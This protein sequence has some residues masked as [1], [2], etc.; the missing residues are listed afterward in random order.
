LTP[1]RAARLARAVRRY[2]RRGGGSGGRAWRLLLA[3]AKRGDAAAA[4]V[5]AGLVE[6]AEPAA[7]ATLW[8]VTRAAGEPWWRGPLGEALATDPERI[9]PSI[10]D[11]FWSGWLST[12]NDE[13]LTRLRRWQRLPSAEP[14]AGLGRV[15]LGLPAPAAD[16]LAAARRDGHPIA[17]IARVRILSAAAH[18]SG[19][20]GSAGQ[21]DP[22][23]Q[24][25]PGGQAGSGSQPNLA[26]RELVEL[27]CAVAVGE[28]EGTIAVFC[29][30]NG[31]V[32]A[33]PVSRAVYLLGMGQI[34]QYCAADP[35]GSLLVAGYP[36]ANPAV[37]RRLREAVVTVGDLDLLA[38]VVRDRGRPAVWLEPAQL[39]RAGRRLAAA[40]AWDRLWRLARDV[41]LRQAIELTRLFDP[42]W[43]PPDEAGRRLFEQLAAAPP[44]LLAHAGKGAT[45]RFHSGQFRRMARLADPATPV[46]VAFAPDGSQLAILGWS[47]S[48]SPDQSAHSPPGATP[49]QVVGYDLPSGEP[50]W[51]HEVVPDLGFQVGQR[52]GALNLAH[53]GD[54]VVVACRRLVRVPARPGGQ[55]SDVGVF[56]GSLTPLPAGAVA[57]ALL[58]TGAGY[59][60][61]VYHP[62]GD[63]RRGGDVELCFGAAGLPP[64]TVRVDGL[65]TAWHL[66]SNVDSGRLSVWNWDWLPSG[67]HSLVDLDETGA[68]RRRAGGTHMG[69][70][71]PPVL[72]AD[73]LLIGVD[74][75]GRLARWRRTGDRLDIDAAAELDWKVDELCLLPGLVGVRHADDWGWF[76]T[77][78]L[79][80]TAA[81]YEPDA[82]WHGPLWTSSDG[83]WAAVVASS[84]GLDLYQMVGV[85]ALLGRPLAALRPAD[86]TVLATSPA[87]S[88][89]ADRM[90]LA[91]LRACADYRYGTEIEVTS[92]GRL[93]LADHD[94]T[95]ADHD[96]TLGEID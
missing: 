25:R 30:E 67:T 2:R 61:Q 5:L 80:D 94:I 17:E 92:A 85:A 38:R 48:A 74:R 7:V 11:T 16:V 81:P 3:R 63:P 91:L 58:P 49:V 33:D 65:R 68:V 41:R 71:P 14:D 82:A 52:Y 27:V 21:A 62:V 90:V 72:A 8:D 26:D 75:A 36:G 28:P 20:P 9:P 69:A 39:D 87:P 88:S 37:Q 22:V 60:A 64:R 24:V 54:E 76:T 57:A 78:D 23:S 51:R 42:G 66:L 95:L 83:Q 40:G 6:D 73:G 31:I 96:I 53:L 34:E 18:A 47:S 70:G 93:P 29:R 79:H 89:D 44:D 12:P 19:G 15:T 13:A 32:P 77:P 55:P 59:V 1:G 43:R 35:D 4:V 45:G 46:G 50:T 86:L 10:V 56:A 84:S